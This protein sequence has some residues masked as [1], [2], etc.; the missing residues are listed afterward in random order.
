MRFDIVTILDRLDAVIAAAR[1]AVSSAAW[2][3]GRTVWFFVTLSAGLIDE[4]C[5]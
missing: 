5:K 2:D 1:S 4:V 3:F